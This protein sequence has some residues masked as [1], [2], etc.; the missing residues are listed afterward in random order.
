M[1]G[2]LAWD[3]GLQSPAHPEFREWAKRNGCILKVYTRPA[4][5]DLID[6]NISK[7]RTAQCIG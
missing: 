2:L 6:L 4:F 5:G 1:V 7:R 3:G